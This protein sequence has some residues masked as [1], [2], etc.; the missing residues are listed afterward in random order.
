MI[1]PSNRDRADTWDPEAAA[2]NLYAWAE[3]TDLCLQLRRAVLAATLPDDQVEQELF[4][5]IRE[6]KERAW[7]K[8]QLGLDVDI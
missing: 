5:S 6:F 7:R 3:L 8:Q 1:C 4:S 2:K